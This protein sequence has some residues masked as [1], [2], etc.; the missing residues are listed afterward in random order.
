MDQQYYKAEEA[1]AYLDLTYTNMRQHI[2]QGNI[3][4]VPYD[5]LPI[6]V[7]LY[8]R[9]NARLFTRTSLDQFAKTRRKVGRNW[10][11]TP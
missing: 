6:E 1:A 3:T 4:P 8:V 7:R 9:K 10:A 11:K 2:H 5:Q